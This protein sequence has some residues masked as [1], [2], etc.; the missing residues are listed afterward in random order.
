MNPRYRIFAILA[1]LL[2]AALGYYAFSVDHSSDQVLLG[3]VD[4]N[5]VIVSA[6]ITGRIQKLLVTEGQDVKAGDLI[7]VLEQDELAAA[8]TASEA[9]AQSNR[10]QIGM[11]QATA[12]STTGDT[13]NTVANAQATHSAA[14]ASLA[15][16]SANRQNQESL[17]RRTVALAAQGIMSAQDQDTSVQALKA[18][19][20]HEQAARDQMAA[21]EAALKAAQARTSQAKAAWENVKSTQSLWASAQAQAAGA[22]ARL[23]YTTIK[24]PISGKVGIWAAREGEVVNSGTAIV[25]LVELQQTWVYAPLPETQADSV[26]LGDV[27]KVRMPGGAVVDGRVIVKT[28]EGDFATQRDVSRLKRDIKTIRL[29]LLIDNPGEQFVPGMTAEVLLPRRRPVRP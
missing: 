29:K 15:E 12:D 22:Q 27:L 26:R 7:A 4:A 3:T 23:G 13:A 16:A 28:A 6:Q 18:A 20:A 14:A 1:V 8:K 17:T 11:L 24:A 2:L 21:A 19:Q 9:Q 5:Q 25:T 10:T